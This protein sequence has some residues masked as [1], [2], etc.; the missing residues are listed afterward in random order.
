MK[1]RKAI[2]QLS[3]PPRRTALHHSCIAILLLCTLHFSLCTVVYAWAPKLGMAGVPF[4]KIGVGRSTGMGEAFVAISDDVSASYYNPSGLAFIKQK[5]FLV[6]HIDWLLDINHEYLSFAA[7]T[8][9]GTIGFAVTAL[10]F[11]D[12]E[13]TTIDQYQG[14]GKTFSANDF[15][16][17]ITYARMFTDKFAFGG[18]VKGIQERIWEM[19][20]TGIAFDFG[21]YYNTGFKS[22]RLGGSISNFGPDI[23]FQGKQLEYLVTENKDWTWPWTYSPIPASFLTEKFS[24]P[25]I[26]RFGLAFDMLSSAPYRITTAIDLVHYNDSPE[27][28]NFGLEAALGNFSL[29]AGYILSTNL[30][31]QEALGMKTGLSYGAGFSF[32]REQFSLRADYAYRDLARLGGSHRVSLGIRI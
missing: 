20:A 4:L 30:E 7:P 6:N 9:F 27:K 18:A 31:Y 12:F 14:T 22:L 26:F 17:S 13:E 15:A 1:I 19:S 16:F 23:S 8:T 5:E 10:T 32:G 29:R 28:L 25:I 11:G 3:H 21:T 2:K 24:L